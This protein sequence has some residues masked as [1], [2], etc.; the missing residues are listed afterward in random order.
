MI[1]SI[2]GRLEGGRLSRRRPFRSPHHAAST[3]AM[4]GGGSQARPGEISPGAQGVLFLDELPEFGRQVLE[5]LRQP[6]EAGRITVARAKAHVTYPGPVPARGRHE[7][8]PLRASGRRG[9]GLRPGA[10]LRRRLPVA[11]LRAAARPHRPACR[12]AGAQRRRHGAAGA[13]RGLVRGG[14]PGGRRHACCRPIGWPGLAGPS[15]APTARPTASSWRPPPCATSRRAAC[16]AAPPQQLQLSARGYHR[17][18]KVA[19]TIADL[20]GSEVDPQAAHRRSRGLPPG[21]ARPLR[22]P[23]PC[24]AAPRRR[25]SERAMDPLRIFPRRRLA[26]SMIIGIGSD[27]DRHTSHRAH[28]R[29]LRRPL[30]RAGLHPAWSGRNRSAGPIAPT[31]MPGA[32]PPRKRCRRRW[33]PAFG[34]A[35]IGATSA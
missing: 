12:G 32:M 15:C 2:G 35:S 25:R 10:A 33:G 9:A 7:P 29:A 22:D 18:L 26:A 3:A 17:V 27:S 11:H 5:S 20:D 14:R 24:A 34:R 8:L 30:H 1:A 19:R 21:G 4:V 6:L 16:C 23:C 28:A 13:A 31:P